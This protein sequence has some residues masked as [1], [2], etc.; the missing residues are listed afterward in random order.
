MDIKLDEGFQFGLGVFETIAVEEGR[1]FL[2]D[3][4]LKRHAEGRLSFLDLVRFCAERGLTEEEVARIYLQ[5][6]SEMTVNTAWSS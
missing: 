1:P 4:H 6:Q 3:R 2:L 5:I